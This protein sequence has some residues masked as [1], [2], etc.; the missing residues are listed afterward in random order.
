MRT[1]GLFLLIIGIICLIVFGIQAMNDSET[2]T[3][4]GLDIAVSKA[5]WAPVIISAIVTAV[6]AFIAIGTKRRG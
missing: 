5:N 1:L 2:F 4:F 6:G 3:L